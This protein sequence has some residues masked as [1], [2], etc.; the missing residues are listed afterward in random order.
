M[1]LHKHTSIPPIPLLW[2]GL[3]ALDTGISAI[4]ATLLAGSRTAALDLTGLGLGATHL[5]GL[6]YPGKDFTGPDRHLQSIATTETKQS[7]SRAAAY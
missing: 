6:N 3:D 2:T 7:N 5:I 4:K 1:T